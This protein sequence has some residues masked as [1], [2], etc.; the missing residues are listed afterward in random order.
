MR[1]PRTWSTWGVVLIVA[2][3]LFSSALLAPTG[4]AL[5]VRT[6][7]PY[8]QSHLELP[9]PICHVF[10]V[11]L[12]NE[13]VGKVLS[14]P[15]Q[16]KFLAQK[17]SFASQYYSVI[18][19]S[20]PNYLA[21]TAGFA[22]NYI[23]VMNRPSV[24]NLIQNHSPAL[25]WDAFMQSMPRHC[26]PNGTQ[27]YRIAHNP[28]VDY[29][30]VWDNQSYCRAHDV[31]FGIWD[32]E[33]SSGHVPNYAFL[34]PNTTNDCWRY[35]EISCDAWLHSW[36][37]PLINNTPVFSHSVFFI[38]YDESRTWDTNSSN[39]SANGGGHVYTVAVSPYACAG[40][41]I[42]TH[43]N[44]YDLLTT[45]EWLLGLGRLGPGAMDNWTPIFRRAPTS[46]RE[47]PHNVVIPR[48]LE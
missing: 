30:T 27:A 45:T 41:N 4:S 44:H 35:G 40:G 46:S 1:L 47:S 19:Y 21:A 31:A 23:T 3:G 33:V 20:F 15:F 36:L 28:F 9:T 26:D 29:A 10:V 7:E 37:S 16:G 6:K 34:S 43:Y 22:T 13:I 39:G 32:S 2:A 42:T 8:C 24:V 12:E 17:Y 14:E 25:S 18:H 38:T 11:F 5:S 48:C